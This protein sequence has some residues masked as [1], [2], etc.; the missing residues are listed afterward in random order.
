MWQRHA[1][2]IAGQIWADRGPGIPSIIT[3]VQLLGAEVNAS[4]QVRTNLDRRI[5]VLPQVLFI[6]F[7]LRADIDGLSRA[8]IESPNE[9][10]P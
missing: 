2:D 3:A 6:S 4:V 1:I 7:G 10:L 9:P 8:T 5:P